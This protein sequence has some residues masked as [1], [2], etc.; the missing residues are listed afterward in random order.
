MILREQLDALKK[1][2]VQ[3]IKIG[4]GS[5]FFYCGKISAPGIGLVS[6]KAKRNAETELGNRERFMLDYPNRRKELI[7][8]RMAENINRWLDNYEGL[9]PD[10]GVLRMW[11][12][13]AEANVQKLKRQ[14]GYQI[15]NLRE[16]LKTWKDF[17]EREVLEIYPSISEPRTIII[18]IE[19]EEVGRTWTTEE[20]K[21]GKI[22]EEER[23]TI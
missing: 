15:K 3:N 11:W 9:A 22:P 10:P 12:D 19:G 23:W 6:A 21:V 5:A 8:A 1:K 16:R 14:Y 2:G 4:S 7:R 17:A 13:D 20:F 18:I